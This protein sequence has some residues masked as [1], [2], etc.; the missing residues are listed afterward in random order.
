MTPRRRN[1][2]VGLVVL[3]G[4]GI[5]T[6]MILLFAGRMASLFAAPGLPVTM[7]SERADGVTQGST[8]Y[9]RGV[10]AGRVTGVHLESDN[11]GV[12]INAEINKQ[13]S[14]PANLVP[15]IRTQSAFGSAAQID[16]EVNG[17]PAGQL[18]A[19]AELRATYEGSALIPKQFTQLAEEVHRQQLLEHVDQAVLSIQQQSER[20]GKLLQSFQQIV[21]DPE[22]RN[23]LRTAVT[24]IRTA[25]E[26]AVRVGN[27]ME[28]F[29]GRLDRIG[30]KADASLSDVRGAVIKLDGILDRFQSVATKIDQ[31]QGT[32]GLLVNDP[33]LY[34]GLLDTTK[35]LNLT[36]STLQRVAQQWEQEGVTLKLAK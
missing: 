28:K 4:L 9:Y 36:V 31:G 3:L 11:Q 6:W 29:T 15:I 27:N 33:K 10:P 2:V 18:L 12:V 13:P 7:K 21:G 24:N 19:N 25:T 30:D 17:P 14:L 35:E 22:T 5:V 20:A 8:I 32:A 34:Q 26:A 23:D 16:L 1:I